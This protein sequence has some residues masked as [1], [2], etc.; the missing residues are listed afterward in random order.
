MQIHILIT[1]EI[2]KHILR[3]VRIYIFNDKK[4]KMANKF[5]QY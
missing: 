2:C 4:Y 3:S 5:D 1:K